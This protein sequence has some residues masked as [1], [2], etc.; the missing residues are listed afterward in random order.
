[1]SKAKEMY[2]AIK[3]GLQTKTL[4]NASGILEY[5]DKSVV[6]DNLP[7]GNS[8]KAY[9]VADKACLPTT[10]CIEMVDAIISCGKGIQSV[11][12][13]KRGTDGC[14]TS[15]AIYKS[16][17]V[18]TTN[19]SGTL[20][21][22]SALN[23]IAK[24]CFVLSLVRQSI[25]LDLDSELDECDFN[26]CGS[27]RD[28]IASKVAEAIYN[29]NEANLMATFVANA[30]V[31]I[32][33]STGDLLDNLFKLWKSVRS[34]PTNKNKNTAIFVNQMVIDELDFLRDE[35]G[36]MIFDTLYECPIT[37][38]QTICRAKMKLVG[39]DD[40]TIPVNNLGQTDAYA[41]CVDNVKFSAT[42]ATIKERKWDEMLVDFIDRMV[43]FNKRNS[44]IPALLPN[45]VKKMT[46][47]IQ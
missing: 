34:V 24:E 7:A 42:P 10:R 23:P 35:Q 45:S 39:V 33:P 17:M 21:D 46:L 18:A 26:D 32:T 6:K 12:T 9:G 2:N 30:G 11:V 16:Q 8:I 40:L 43:A 37:G 19:V 3:N 36:R 22:Q 27:L 1:M 13:N 15:F 14:P 47:T 44:G 4:G 25:T 20:V 29:G 28:Y 31:A 5:I 41:V 38:C